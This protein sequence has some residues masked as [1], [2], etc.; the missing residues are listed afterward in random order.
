M[1]NAVPVVG[2]TGPTGAGK[3]TWAKAFASYGC[4]VIDC[5]ALSRRAVEEPEVLAALQEAFGGDIVKDGALNRRLLAQRAFAGPEQAARLNAITHPAIRA[6]L[7]KALS[8]AKAQHPP[9][10]FVD[11]PLLFEGGIDGLCDCTAAVLAPENV[12][13]ERICLR[14][15]ITEAEAR[16]P[17]GKPARRRVF[18]RAC[19]CRL[20][21]RP[22]ARG[23]SRKGAF[24]AAGAGRR[25]AMTRNR[26]APQPGKA[27]REKGPLRAFG[28]RARRCGGELWR[29]VR[30]AEA[31]LCAVP[32][33]LCAAGRT[34]GA[35]G[36]PGPESRVRGDP[37]GKAA[38]TPMRFP[39]PARW[40]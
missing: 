36:R 17:H 1:P 24:L 7:Y 37:P 38:S 13:L 27:A 11:A 18:P 30:K 6:M 12:R 5:D 19:G 32:A 35:G 31:R 3:S 40:G 25:C 28:R 2:L 22:A 34:A 21:R 9:M 20:R 33:H 29:A 39:T 23:N 15:G 8:D 10:I 4:I 26:Y 16:A 14:D